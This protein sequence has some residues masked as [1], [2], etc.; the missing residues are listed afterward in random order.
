M[1]STVQ[2]RIDDRMRSGLSRTQRISTKNTKHVCLCDAF[3]IGTPSSPEFGVPRPRCDKF[4]Q[5]PW[6]WPRPTRPKWACQAAAIGHRNSTRCRPTAV[7]CIHEGGLQRFNP[8]FESSEV[9]LVVCLHKYTVQAL[10]ISL[11]LKFSTG[12]RYT[13]YTA[14]G[15]FIP[16]AITSDLPVDPTSVSRPLNRPP[17]GKFLDPPFLP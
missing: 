17:F 5:W 16:Q 8:P 7:T 11:N 6:P 14:S 13:I 9:F 3:Y 2:L 10:L 15:D 12:K 4:S 1:S